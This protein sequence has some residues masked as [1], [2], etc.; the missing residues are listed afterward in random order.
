MMQTGFSFYP[1]NKNTTNINDYDLM[2]IGK[3]AKDSEQI[4]TKFNTKE[5]QQKVQEDCKLI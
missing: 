2:M 5:L 3:F 4:V 1:Q